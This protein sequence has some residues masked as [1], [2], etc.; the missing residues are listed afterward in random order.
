MPLAPWIGPVNDGITGL[1]LV[2]QLADSH[3]INY[4]F[5][6]LPG[7]ALFLVLSPFLGL[8]DYNGLAR[9]TI[10]FLVLFFI[11]RTLYSVYGLGFWIVCIGSALLYYDSRIFG[12]DEF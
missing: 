8:T 4:L 12:E 9:W 6:L 3:W 1:D 11:A 5:Y 10:I 2:K 7:A